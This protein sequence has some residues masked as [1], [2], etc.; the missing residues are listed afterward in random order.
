M[1]KAFDDETNKSLRAVARK[2]R[3]GQFKEK[4]VALAVELGVTPSF[5]SDFLNAR[6]GAGLDMLRGLARF[7]PLEVLAILR[8][9]PGVIVTLV[10]GRH[11]ELEA[12]LALMPEI[13]RR[14]ARA[15]VEL[16]GC[17]PGAAG[18]AAVWCFGEHGAVPDTDVDWWLGKIRKRLTETAKSGERPSEKVRNARSS[19]G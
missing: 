18:D 2:L 14:A 11:E 7:A 1:A 9:D 10:E 13:V 4:Q 8:V 19:R 17:T 16:E 12:G 3:A 5:L 6:K 15:A